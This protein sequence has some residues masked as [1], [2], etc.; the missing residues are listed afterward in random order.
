MTIE[1]RRDLALLRLAAAIGQ[2]DSQLTLD[3]GKLLEQHPGVSPASTHTPPAVQA[4]EQGAIAAEAV[5]QA[6]ERTFRPKV[7]FNGA[8]AGRASGANLDGTIDN[9]RG[10]WPDVP[11]WAA[12]VT[13]TF[14]ILD[15][16][17]N[18][19]R[20]RGELA[21]VHAA[22]AR[23]TGASQRARLE[24]L[25]AR[26]MADAAAKIA[27]NIPLQIAAATEAETQARARYEAGLTGITEL[28]E[29][30]R[31]LAQAES[32]EALA[33]LAMWRAR[34]AAAAAAGDLAPFLA[35]AAQPSG[36]RVK[37]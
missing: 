10:L 15:F 25:Q 3:P 18:R 4:A 19:A 23:V 12:G 13:V 16:T 31:L 30:Q 35:E 22:Q 33:S 27:L 2:P 14:P 26:V 24:Q 37:P 36:P 5:R 20:T 1:Q 17:A 6:A 7:F 29:A 28:A 8:L 9:G 11:N 32:E 21:N 34:L